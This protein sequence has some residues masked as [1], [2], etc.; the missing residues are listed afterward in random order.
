M[1]LFLGLGLSLNS[2]CEFRQASEEGCKSVLC[3]FK[4][5]Y[6]QTRVRLK[7]ARQSSSFF[8]FKERYMD[9]KREDLGLLHRSFK[10]VHIHV[11]KHLYP[12]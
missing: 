6:K 10:G 3:F 8:N 7:D 1:H 5:N 12:A 2:I 9:R 4:L 11:W